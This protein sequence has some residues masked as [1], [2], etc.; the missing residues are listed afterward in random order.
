MGIAIVI[1]MGIAY[2]DQHHRVGLSFLMV[3][4]AVFAFGLGGLWFSWDGSGN[5]RR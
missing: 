1:L 3:A 5:H 4:P 2:L